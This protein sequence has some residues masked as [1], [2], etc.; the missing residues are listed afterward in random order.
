MTENEIHDL[1]LAITK[2]A[3]VKKID[4][5]KHDLPL[6]INFAHWT[7]RKVRDKIES[8]DTDIVAG[9]LDPDSLL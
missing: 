4:P 7:Y 2:H 6:M 8:Q 3:L 5:L 1:S 9:D